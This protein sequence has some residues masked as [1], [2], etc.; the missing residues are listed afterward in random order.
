MFGNLSSYEKRTKIILNIFFTIDLKL[1]TPFCKNSFL[2][3]K[4]KKKS[5]NQ[6]SIC[7]VYLVFFPLYYWVCIYKLLLYQSSG[8]K[9]LYFL[10]ATSRFLELK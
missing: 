8:T 4:K 5:N 7:Q 2:K 10:F 1:R 6:N 9:D 3:Q